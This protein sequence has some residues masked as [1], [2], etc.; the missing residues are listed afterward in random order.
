[1]NENTDLRDF[2]FMPLDVARLRDSDL[3]A[4]ATGDEFRAAVLLW[5]AAWHQ[6]PAGSLPNDDRMLANLSG[7][8]R[9]VEGW[10]AV[11]EMALRGFG[12]RDDKRLHH[13]VI[14]EK[15][16]DSWSKK[17]AYQARTQER[18]DS[19]RRGAASRWHKNEPD[20][21]ANGS[22]MAQLDSSAMAQLD[23]SA[24]A[25]LDGSP[26]AQLD[27]SPMAQLD[28]SAMAQ[29]DSSAMAQLD[30]SANSSPMAQLDGEREKEKE[31]EKEKE[32]RRTPPVVPP[33]GERKGKR[34]PN[35]W[36]PDDLLLAWARGEGVL[37]NVIDLETAKFRDYWADIPG[38]KGRKITWSGT[39]KNWIRRNAIPQNDD[40]DPEYDRMMA[41]NEGLL[42]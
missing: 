41:A 6:I 33:K 39:W 11:K 29:L 32:N 24:M 15:A 17:Q 9:D 37:E 26:M 34:L 7:Y 21:S 40:S 13:H 42:E 36:E 27:S 23:S 16:E 5:C 35:D 10:L 38:A 30:G 28:S 18:S 8:G 22:A 19:G 31:K 12:I 20:S 3:A 14:C 4:L 1:M 2:E 25:Q